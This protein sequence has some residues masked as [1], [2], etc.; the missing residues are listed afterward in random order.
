MK[1]LDL[2]SGI[3]GLSLGLER[4]GFETAAFC[5]IE[6]YP[7]AVLQKHWPDVPIYRDVRELTGEQ[8][9]ADGIVPDV[10]AGGYPCQPW[11]VAGRQKGAK[12]PRH[13]WPEMHRLIRECRPSWVICENVVGHIKLG[14]DAVLDDL[15]G[16]DYTCWPFVIPAVAVGALHKRDRI[17]VVAH[18]RHWG[19]RHVG[20]S[21]RGQDASGERSQDNDQARGSGA[22][23]ALVGNAEHLGSSAASKRR[24]PKETGR[25]SSQGSIATEQ[26]S[27]ASRRENN[28]PL[29]DNAKQQT[30]GGSV[31]QKGW[32]NF[33]G[34]G[35][36]AVEPDVGRVA[37][38][39][40]H[41]S[42]RIKGL[43]N[44]V[45]PQVAEVI[46]RAIMRYIDA[47]V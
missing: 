45:V 16:E 46:G 34:G 24:E 14:L 8:L 35:E 42:H 30:G 4:A 20:T 1:V 6:E 41:R 2:F 7:R 47:K 25:G 38:G 33:G 17:F 18:T 15:E 23:P 19:G 13:L 10:I 31:Q 28:E 5:E 44:A 11:S 40:S 26:S 21:Q 12:D 32:D 27:G 29:A 39:V 37:N 3:G 9:R 43:G 36:W 22:Q